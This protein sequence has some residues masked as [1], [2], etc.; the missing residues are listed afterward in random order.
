MRPIRI[1][2]A[3]L[4][5]GAPT[6]G[7]QL[8]YES[9]AADLERACPGVEPAPFSGQREWPQE[10]DDPKL[11]ELATVMGVCR[12]HYEDL[13]RGF[14]EGVRPVTLG[15][16]HSLAMPAIAAA[17]RGVDR[18]AV[19]YLD[20]HA[21]INTPETSLSGRIHGMPLAQALGL[22]PPALSFGGERIAGRD[23]YILGARSIDE[24]EFR[25]MREQGVHLYPADRLLKE[26]VEP[27]LREVLSAIQGIPFH[28]SLDVDIMDG[29]EFPATGYRMPDG[30]SYEQTRRLWRAFLAADPRSVSLVEYDPTRG[31]ERERERM[32][33]LIGDLSDWG[34]PSSGAFEGGK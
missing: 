21:D 3:P 8:A 25:I 32:L 26:G 29:E 7:T 17:A 13:K 5:A 28:L 20:G 10:K 14:A 9:L 12:C 15:G 6:V 19:V 31:G 2:E 27:V 1:Y 34:K 11:R 23:L 22:C 30:L 4:T 18:L 33:E 24:G 16:D